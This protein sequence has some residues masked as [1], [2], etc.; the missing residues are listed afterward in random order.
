V[1]STISVGPTTVTV[2]VSRI[3]ALDAPSL[4]SSSP[5]STIRVSSGPM[6]DVTDAGTSNRTRR[7]SPG[8][9]LTRAKPISFTTGRVTDA[10]GSC[11]YSWTTSTPSRAPTFSTVNSTP[12]HPFVASSS[13]ST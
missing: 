8:V 13:R 6:N 12:T 4:S 5:G 1:W 7:C 9:A 3:S 11:R 2:A 10:A